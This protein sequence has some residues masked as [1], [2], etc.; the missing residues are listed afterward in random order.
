MGEGLYS[1]VVGVV[2][3]VVAIVV[4]IV[5]VHLDSDHLVDPVHLVVDLVCPV[6][7]VHL[8]PLGHLGHPAGR[9]R[10]FAQPP[11]GVGQC[12]GRHQGLIDYQIGPSREEDVIR[13]VREMK[14]E[15]KNYQ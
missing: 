9:Y 5:V 15:K 3:F 1:F 8:V 2:A 6:H 7:P 11:Q 10:Y 4:A 13:A 14:R 12:Y